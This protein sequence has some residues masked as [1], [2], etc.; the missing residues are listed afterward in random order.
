MKKQIKLVFGLAATL[1][2]GACGAKTPSEP[3]LPPMDEAVASAIDEKL[4]ITGAEAV[5]G[6]I[7][8]DEEIDGATITWSSSDESIINPHWDGEKAPGVVTR[9]SEDTT[10][11][12]TAKAVKDGTEAKFT[13][14]VTVKGLEY[15]IQDEDYK[16]YLFG[17]FISEDGKETGGQKVA[18]GEQMYFA[19][20]D[21]DKGLHFKD[22]SKANN[23]IL[24]S[25]VGERGVRD[26]FMMRSP[27]GD[28]FFIVAT[29]L[30][31]Y[32][33]GGW[34][35]NTNDLFSRTGSDYLTFWE[36]KD[37]INW[38]E[39]KSIKVSPES[40]GMCWAPEMIW[41]EET[42]QYV[43]FFA[44]CLV[45]TPKDKNNKKVEQD[46]IYYV[47][48][49]DFV[50]I[51]EAQLLIDNQKLSECDKCGSD[52]L[53]KDPANYKQLVCQDCGAKSEIRISLD[54]SITCIDGTYYYAIKDGDN[55][56]N[57]GGILIAKTDDL[58]DYTSWEK[59]GELE[60]TGLKLT[61]GAA[62]T[63]KNLEGPEW[64]IY[65]QNDRQDPDQIEIGLMGDR[66]M[67]GN[68][69]I[70]FSTTNIDDIHNADGSWKRLVEGADKDYSWDSLRKR[71][72]T[73][74][75]ITEDECEAI[76][77]HYGLE[78]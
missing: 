68:G 16:G 33:R 78:Y 63:N 53:E 8:L 12:L 74:M 57:G 47:T 24:S 9:P 76:R 77:N 52:N 30:S 62:P 26:P 69:Y 72:G 37:L 38:E 11:T 50:H 1:F 59:V 4:E 44:S 10:V 48:T 55:N 66:Y 29:D 13:R 25:V 35:A 21:A 20:A 2:L 42:G 27:E 39:S 61:D 23:P 49:R 58:F 51:S 5:Y 18:V 46:A 28:R 65:N 15:H 7:Y 19:F 40:A 41:H 71:H 34:G 75:R 32:T 64:F 3:P 70:P 14:E 54:A 22:L 45:D 31:V 17:H 73:I 67:G 60:E 56:V 43:I 6:N 36:S